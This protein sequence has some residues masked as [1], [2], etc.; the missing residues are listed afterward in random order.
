MA[1]E[2]EPSS[3]DK[4]I[5]GDKVSSHS[6]FWCGWIWCQGGP[7]WCSG[8]IVDPSDP[9]GYSTLLIPV[10][11]PVS[12]GEWLASTTLP[13]SAGQSSATALWA[14]MLRI[15]A[16]PLEPGRGA[17]LA[18]RNSPLRPPVPRDGLNL[19]VPSGPNTAAVPPERHYR[20]SSRKVMTCV[21][22]IQ[23]AGVGLLWWELGETP[24]SHSGRSLQP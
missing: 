3:Q 24:C 5:D 16:P 13:A 6:F 23:K 19:N 8:V 20:T 7:I 12:G 4:G 9:L 17:A 15:T 14:H 11:V 1:H 21:F 18:G 22:V 2:F 10:R